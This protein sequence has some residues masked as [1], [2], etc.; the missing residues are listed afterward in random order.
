MS[1]DDAL[2]QQN[3][4]DTP[5]PEAK[6]RIEAEAWLRQRLADG[7]WHPIAEIHAT[8]ENVGLAWRTVQR[9]AT[10]IR[11]QREQPKAGELGHWR[12]RAV[13]TTVK[14]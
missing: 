6:A 9:A 12:L 8:A 14:T 3:A 7:C 1:A 11:V 5:G 13:P 4:T 10:E 2:A